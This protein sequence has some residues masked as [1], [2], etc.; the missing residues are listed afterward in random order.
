MVTHA[1]Q[2]VK[3][4]APVDSGIA[5]IVSA[6][7]EFPSLETVESCEG[8]EKRA[9]WVCFR[10][11]AYWKHAWHELSE[12]IIGIL[13]PRLIDEVGDDASVKIQV[14]PSGQVFGELS[15]RPGAASRV[16]AAIRGL[17]RESSVCLRRSSG[18]CDGTSGTCL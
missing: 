9:A 18:C 10:Y 8:N 16:E 15:V 17:A 14:T 13:A 2:W 4:N 5:G 6:L 3:V 11:G 1:Q 7:A 12:F